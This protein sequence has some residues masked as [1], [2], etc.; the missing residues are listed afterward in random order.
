MSQIWGWD[1]NS[2]VGRSRKVRVNDN[3]ELAI[4][5]SFTANPEGLLAGV[6]Y[7]HISASPSFDNTTGTTTI[8]FKEGGSGGT[9]VAVVVLTFNGSNELTTVERTA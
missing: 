1:Y 6:E 8:T 9:T 5:G 7:D 4:E 2:P 3:G